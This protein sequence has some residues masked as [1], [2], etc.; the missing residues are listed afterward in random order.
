MQAAAHFMQVCRANLCILQQT[1]LY[2]PL[3]SHGSLVSALHQFPVYGGKINFPDPDT[4][5]Y[6]PKYA[7]GDNNS[8]TL[9]GNLPAMV[10]QYSYGMYL[11]EAV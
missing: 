2:I 7:D 9:K 1:M 5:G 8:Y 10:L 6:H 4:P 11:P 3:H